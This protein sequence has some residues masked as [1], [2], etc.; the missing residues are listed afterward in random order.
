MEVAF[1]TVLMRI[2]ARLIL[3]FVTKNIKIVSKDWNGINFLEHQASQVGCSEIGL[4][5][6]DSF[7]DK[8]KFIYAIGDAVD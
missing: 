1:L 3:S 7:A 2:T 4:S 6:N 5:A 8:P